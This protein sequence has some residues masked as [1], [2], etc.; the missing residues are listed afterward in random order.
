MTENGD[1]IGL[2]YPS[3]QLARAE[4]D[5]N[6]EKAGQW[7]AVLA[8]MLRGRLRIGSRTPVRGLPVWVTPEVIHG[9]FATGKAAASGPLSAAEME[10]ARRHHLEQSRAEIFGHRLDPIRRDELRTLLDGHGADQH[11]TGQH[12]TGQHPTDQ[13]PTDQHWTVGLPEEAVLPVLA[14]LLRADDE[15]AALA[16]LAEVQPYSGLLCFTPRTAPGPAVAPELVW[17]ATAGEA[18]GKLRSREPKPR[19]ETMRDT[20]AVWNLYADRMLALWLAS[21]R[22]GRVGVH[23]DVDW[24]R[25]ARALLDE[26]PL[27]ARRH[28]PSRRHC[29][30]KA[31][32][33]VLREAL[34]DVLDG[35]EWRR[36]MTQTVVD[37]MV[38]RR[39][40]P[41]GT[42]HTALRARQAADAARPAHHV[43]AAAVAERLAALPQ[44]TGIADTEPLLQPVPIGPA[45][46]ESAL[47]K[48]ALNGPAL[49][50]PVPVGAAARP[51]AVPDPIRAVVRRATA[52]PVEDLVAAGLVPSAE[53]L[54]GLVPRVT[55]QAVGAA[56]PDPD[57]SALMAANYLAFRN[58]R[59]LLLTDL[60]SQARLEELPWVRAVAAHRAP[61]GDSR[62]AAAAALRRLGSLVLSAFPGTLLP[63]PMV[64]ELTALSREA[65]L[66]LPWVEELAADIFD[67]R[68]TAKFLYAAQRAGG[69][70][71]GTLYERYYR[72]DY[73]AIAG[74]TVTGKRPPISPD[75]A[76]LCRTR[77]G[78]RARN[79][80][81]TNGMIIEQAQI[82]TTHNLATL[83]TGAGATVDATAAAR[84]CWA[85]VER[86][87]ARPMA[88]RTLKDIAYAWRQMIFFLSLGGADSVV[89]DLPERGLLAP[90]V[91]G[92]RTVLAGGEARPLTGW[93]AGRHWL[94]TGD[95]P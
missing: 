86:L 84:S 50:G 56:Y 62:A 53:V 15:T 75:F 94:L 52:A 1:D 28:P 60:E 34:T 89:E 23:T 41:G 73:A 80:P 36:G 92:L 57:L 37:A 13:H 51:V 63:N 21:M 43:I 46:V 42:E 35:R 22:D 17:R 91:A 10:Y 6:A 11:Q 66:G 44:H 38:R 82:L 72:I 87:A 32:L 95:Q 24:K 12:R 85:T 48:P 2:G 4:A 65:D 31:N 29:G 39:G 64:R 70:L 90:A 71:A 33:T 40:T 59:S 30:P 77:A 58:R 88:L 47:V 19:I 3:G 79:L 74:L 69:L 78:V 25:E 68:F 7:R 8:G 5:G 16:L 93:T 20:L 83:V 9:G 67:G 54:A 27:L 14:W 81:A 76:A 45:L 26:Y 61:G 18:A 49:N 55:A